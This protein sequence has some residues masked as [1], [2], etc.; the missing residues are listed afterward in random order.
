MSGKVCRRNPHSVF[1]FT[2]SLS[3][4]L[5]LCRDPTALP[6]DVVNAN[7]MNLASVLNSNLFTAISLAFFVIFIPKGV[8]FVSFTGSNF[9]CCVSVNTACTFLRARVKMYLQNHTH[10]LRMWDMSVR[11]QIVYFLGL[12]SVV[13]HIFSCFRGNAHDCV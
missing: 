3:L 12:T 1:S 9:H 5:S 10:A 8:Q 7:V 4:P 2:T 6:N 11:S 13:C